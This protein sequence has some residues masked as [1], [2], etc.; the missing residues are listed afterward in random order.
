MIVEPHAYVDQTQGQVVIK[1]G[2]FH[3]LSNFSAWIF[4]L[5]LCFF[6]CWPYRSGL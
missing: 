3:H 6:L 4:G 5:C 1:T 2:F